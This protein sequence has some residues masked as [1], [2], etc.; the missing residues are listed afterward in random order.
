MVSTT[1]TQPSWGGQ[2]LSPES[3]INL[4]TTPSHWI[5]DLNVRVDAAT[6]EPPEVDL[7]WPLRRPY[8][9]LP[10][11]PYRDQCQLSPTAL[12]DWLQDRAAIPVQA[13]CE[14]RW[15]VNYMPSEGLPLDWF[16]KDQR[17]HLT[18]HRM[19]NIPTMTVLAHRS[20]HRKTVLD[21]TCLLCGA[22]PEM[23]PHL[24][25][26]SAQAHEWGPARRRLAAW[27]DRNMGDRAAP[28]RHQLWEPAVLQQ[29]AAALRTPSMLRAPLECTGPLT[30]GNEFIRQVV[31]ESIRVWYAHAKARATLLKARLSPGSTMAWALQEQ[32]LHQQA[33]KEGVQRELLV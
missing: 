16:I 4:V 29:W 32:R 22:Q 8:S 23:A 9:F 33:E 30:L 5:T 15:G 14:A 20:S 21:T 24:W 12:S 31:E 28:V 26:C 1:S 18:A 10:L 19:D 7:T 3:A 2:R 11:V 13:G 27:L 6:Q 25:V 17:R